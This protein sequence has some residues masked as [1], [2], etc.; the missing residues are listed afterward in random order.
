M[1]G[2]FITFE[3]IEGSGKTTQL[4]R[5][6]RVLQGPG[7]AVVVTREP[8]GTQL[9]EGLRELLLGRGP[10]PEPLAEL[11]MLLADR[12]QHVAEIIRPA[13]ARGCWV[14]ADR[15]I[16]ATRAYQIGARGLDEALV[17]HAMLAATGGLCP[18]LT[19]LLD[20]TTEVAQE[21][22]GRRGAGNRLDREALEFHRRVASAYRKQ[23]R[24]EPGRIKLIDA[25][26]PPDAV[27]G[28][29]MAVVRALIEG[30]GSD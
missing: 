1:H 7:R 14:I 28:Q 3:G 25:S 9:G 29:I 2:R 21:R 22:V 27:H 15:Y 19:L 17:E 23:L 8:G 16:D 10:T 5:L 12:A 6:A 24:R 20:L 11:F 4:E 13:L 18:D 26:L 30:P